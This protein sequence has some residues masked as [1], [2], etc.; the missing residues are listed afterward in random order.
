M[1]IAYLTFTLC[2]IWGEMTV[3]HNQ[4]D[5]EILEAVVNNVNPLGLTGPSIQPYNSMPSALRFGIEEKIGIRTQEV[6]RHAVR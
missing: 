1:G 2:T 4:I 6:G 5:L 3:V